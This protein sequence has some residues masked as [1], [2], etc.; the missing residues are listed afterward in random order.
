[1]QIYS[2]KQAIQVNH[3]NEIPFAGYIFFS[4]SSVQSSVDSLWA[5]WNNQYEN[6][7]HWQILLLIEIEKYAMNFNS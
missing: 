5:V 7:L 4:V 3:E 2:Y 6:M 1:M